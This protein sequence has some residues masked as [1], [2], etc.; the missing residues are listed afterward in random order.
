MLN[1]KPSLVEL[2][3]LLFVY[4]GVITAYGEYIISQPV[5]MLIQGAAT[6]L[7]LVCTGWLIKLFINFIKSLN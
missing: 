1:Y 4:I 6:F 5:H 3:V 7:M 2:L